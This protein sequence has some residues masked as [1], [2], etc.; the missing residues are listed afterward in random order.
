MKD[1]KSI[2]ATIPVPVSKDE[3]VPMEEEDKKTPSPLIGT[4]T[5]VTPMELEKEV[6]VPTLAFLD[7]D[8]YSDSGLDDFLRDELKEDYIGPQVSPV[9]PFVVAG[10]NFTEGVDEANITKRRRAL[11][12]SPI[13]PSTG[14]VYA[15]TPA[16]APYPEYMGSR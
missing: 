4:L 16:G 3:E 5:G 10:A 7:E 11:T 8:P 6:K 9:H 14:G 2:Q 12:L 13:D 15:I 1:A